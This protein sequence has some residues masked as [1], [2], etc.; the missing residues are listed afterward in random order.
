M[1][2][3]AHHRTIR[4]ITGAL[5]RGAALSLAGAPSASAHTQADLVAVPAGTQTTITL[6][7]TH[8]CGGS[9]TVEVA[10]QAPVAG[11]VAGEVAGWTATSEPDGRGNTVLEWSGGVLPDGEDGAFPVTFTA[12]A[13][14]GELLVFPSVQECENGETLSWIDGDPASEYPAPRLL[15]L[16]PGSEPAT[17]ID[18][19]PADAPGR[20]LL[21]GI[22]D[23]DNPSGST[24]TS[25]Q[26]SST[27][28]TG[29]GGEQTTPSSVGATDSGDQTSS[30]DQA[31]AGDAAGDQVSE[32][33]P[34]SSEDSSSSTP[35]VI[36]GVLVLGGAVAVGVVLI[37]RR[38]SGAAQ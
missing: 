13:T 31:G 9:P 20:E 29:D 7:P 26:E 5:A 2:A 37:R 28:A 15:I 17:S 19:V 23:V 14:V 16:A 33:A 24:T 4:R 25:P 36:L 18:Q 11:A 8:G 12:P 35:L 27:T 10:I 3:M 6:R 32:A 21:T 38:P 34:T 30:A 22:I 1:D